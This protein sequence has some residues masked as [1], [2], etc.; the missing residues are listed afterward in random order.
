[1]ATITKRGNAYRIKVSCGYDT[2]GK[3]VIQSLTW[4]PNE[5]M[6]ARQIEK[7]AQKQAMLFEQECLKGA[8]AT[9]VK[10]QTLAEEWFGT[11]AKQNLRLSTYEGYQ[12]YEKRVYSAIGHLRINRITTRDIQRFINNLSQDGVNGRTGKG[13][14]PKTIR[15]YNGFISGIFSYAIKMGMVADNPCSRVTLPKKSQTE[16]K[17]YTNEQTEKFLSLLQAEPLKYRLF[18]TVLTYSGLRKGECL[19]IEYKDIN[20]QSGVI[21]ISRSSLYTVKNGTYTDN[22]KTERSKRFI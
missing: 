8:T 2:S 20:W 7:E 15:N 9:A 3:Q 4:K 22:T 12:K 11:Y 5:N 19:G 6:T 18:F 21:K 10:F 1:M 13:L 14:S 17:I 16:K